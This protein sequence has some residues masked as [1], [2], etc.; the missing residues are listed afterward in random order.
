[1]TDKK[2]T[3]ALT[4]MAILKDERKN[5]LT[6][7]T[8]AE[9]E[10]LNLEGLLPDAVNT[11]E[12]Q[13]QR[14]LDQLN[15]KKTGLE[16]YITLISLFDRNETLFYHVVMS[17]PIRFAPILYTPTVGE[18]CV[19]FDHIFRRPRGM[20]ISLR[21]KGR[22][23][24]VL[25]NWPIEDVRFI[26]VTTGGRILGLG[27][28]GANGMGIPIGK[29]QMYTACAAVPPDTLL[30]LL[31]DCGTD[32]EELLNDPLYLGLRK[33]RPSD[34]EMDE[35]VDEFIEATQKVFPNC[36]VHFEDWKGTDA[37][38]YLAKYRDKICCY[39]DDI[40]GTASVVLAG[41][42]AT[43]NVKKEKM[44]DQRIFFLGAGSAALGIADLLVKAMQLEGTAE[45]E[46]RSTIT[47]YDYH[48]L[49]ETSR[50]D[51]LPL[52]KL[53]AK[54]HAP[55][56]N[57]LE[58]IKAFKPTMLLG[59]STQGNAFTQPIIEAMAEFNHQ[60]VI[61]A[62]SNPTE[63]SECTAEDAYRWTKGNVLF[64]SGTKFPD[65]KIGDKT[66]HPGQ[67]NNVYIFPAL[68]LAVYATQPKRITDEMFIEAA[69]ATAAQV[70]AEE[71]TKGMI[72]PPLND[73]LSTEINTAAKIAEYIFDKN[74]ATVSRPKDIKSWLKSQLYKPEYIND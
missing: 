46:A 18:A 29:L 15:Q 49:I 30:P 17:D 37:I 68:G 31:L 16:Q 25:R 2:A 27:D 69:R 3:P 40:Q 22:I 55:T 14:I 11:I 74:L 21:H 63:K 62:L 47:L 35:F 12:Q 71:Y 50:T 52:Q 42:M 26:C 32:N 44:S 58:A 65:V 53:Y 24:K 56:T 48:G 36:C 20:Y 45:K 39:N 19:K 59:L 61:F 66:F 51:L 34:A 43:L 5:K 8:Y 73:I 9:R 1:M 6:A 28:L 67:A 41:L 70:T 72:F 64:A 13:K 33:H 57:L 54:T 7:F 38:K 4:G 10:D 23:E 60:P